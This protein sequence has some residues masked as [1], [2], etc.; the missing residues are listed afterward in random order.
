[1]D[2]VVRGASSIAGCHFD[3]RETE[4][5]FEFVAANLGFAALT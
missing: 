5:A 1:L 2:L 4:I 3:P